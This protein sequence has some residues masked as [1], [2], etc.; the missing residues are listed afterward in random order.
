M[1]FGPALLVG[2][3]VVPLLTWAVG[4]RVLGPYSRGTE[5]HNTPLALLGD[6]FAGLGHGSVVFWLVALGPALFVAL[7]RVIAYLIRPSDE[8]V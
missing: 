4:S 2:L 1:I 6:F 8:K 3:L 7:V 5:V